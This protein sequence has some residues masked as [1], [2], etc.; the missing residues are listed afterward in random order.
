MREVMARHGALSGAVALLVVDKSAGEEEEWVLLEEE[1]VLSPKSAG[2]QSPD[3]DEGRKKTTEKPGSSG[4]TQ[5][6]LLLIT[7]SHGSPSCAPCAEEQH[8]ED[9]DWEMSADPQEPPLPPTVL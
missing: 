7:A 9:E 1:W 2:S 6:P 5:F 8:E 4:Q 3:E